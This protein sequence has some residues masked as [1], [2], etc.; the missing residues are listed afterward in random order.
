M[1]SVDIY[2]KLISEKRFSSKT[3]RTLIE[4]FTSDK[5][6][7]VF[8][9]PFRRLQQ[10]AQVFSLETNAAVRSR[11]THTLEVATIGISI[12]EKVVESLIENEKIS[13]K[14]ELPFIKIVENAC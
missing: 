3:S 13:R 11:L 2:N 9:S 10:K 8:S 5:I 7:I 14:L 12:A 6:R 1:S 4:E